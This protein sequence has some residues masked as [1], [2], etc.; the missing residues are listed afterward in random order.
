[1]IRISKAEKEFKQKQE[2]LAQETCR[3]CQ[4]LQNLSSAQSYFF[5]LGTEYNLHGYEEEADSCWKVLGHI[6]K[7][8]EL[9]TDRQDKLSLIGRIFL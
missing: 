1:M 2:E 8:S 9:E 5:R 3:S 4:T 6:R 7:L